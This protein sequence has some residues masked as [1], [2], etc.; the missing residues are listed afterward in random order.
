MILILSENSDSSTEQVMDWIERLGHRC[1]RVNGEDVDGGGPFT[2]WMD[3]TGGW[4]DSLTNTPKNE[5][6]AVWYRRWGHARRYHG[7]SLL[8][9]RGAGM[10]PY[11]VS[12]S[13]SFH[14]ARELSTLSEGVFSAYEAAYWLGDPSNDTPNK[15]LVIREAV[16]AGLDVPVTLV[17]SDREAVHAFAAEYGRIIMKPLGDVA[18]F[19]F[20]RDFYLTYTTECTPELLDRGPPRFFPTLFQERLEKEYELRVFYLA[21]DLYA[22][23][24]FSQGDAQT[25]GDFRRYNRRKPNRNVPYALPGEVAERLRALMRALKLNTGSLDLVRTT[26]GRYVFLEVNPI[27]QFGMVSDPCNYHL[28]RR[29]AQHL[30]DVS[31]GRDV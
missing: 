31:S 11:K 24:I 30:I 6:K 2:L 14:L 4:F 15:L 3:E 1:I 16:R 21:G 23:A 12:L 26:D 22:M 7:V 27:G 25:E 29:I 9:D 13:A 5:V 17:S 18:M 8:N 28:E 19:Q 10:Q 20:G